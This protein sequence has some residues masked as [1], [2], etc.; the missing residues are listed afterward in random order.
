MWALARQDTSRVPSRIRVEFQRRKIDAMSRP[1]GGTIG[2][3]ANMAACFPKRQADYGS[4]S[5]S[6]SRM[7]LANAKGLP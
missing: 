5:H 6:A 2:S 4:A 1:S 3:R 7:A